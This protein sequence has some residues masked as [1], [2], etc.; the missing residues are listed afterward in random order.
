MEEIKL[1]VCFLLLALGIVYFDIFQLFIRF[2][3]FEVFDVFDGFVFLELLCLFF[4]LPGSL[5]R[6]FVGVLGCLLLRLEGFAIFE[7]GV[8]QDLGDV[9]PIL[10]IDPE[11]L[12][13]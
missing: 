4:A 3:L 11:Y 10:G 12:F 8:L 6:L 5:L 9:W 13:D 7:V 1:F 2:V